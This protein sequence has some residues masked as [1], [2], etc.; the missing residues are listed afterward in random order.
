MIIK[1]SVQ[2]NTINPNDWKKKVDEEFKDNI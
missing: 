1:F 2:S